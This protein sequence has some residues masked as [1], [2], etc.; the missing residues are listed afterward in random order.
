MNFSSGWK[1]NY[2]I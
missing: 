2:T 1:N